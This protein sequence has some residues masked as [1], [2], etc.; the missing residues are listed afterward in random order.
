MESLERR[1]PAWRVT[2]EIGS[3]EGVTA[4][5]STSDLHWGEYERMDWG[6]I[7][8]GVKS[9][10]KHHVCHCGARFLATAL[11]ACISRLSMPGLSGLTAF[12][13]AVQHVSS[14]HA[15]GDQAASCYCMRKGLIRKA[16]LAHNMKKWAAKH[17]GMCENTHSP[18]L[19][20][21][22]P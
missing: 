3:E 5:A 8:E 7:H 10:A 18:I 16:H 22:S 4:A 1:Q 19:H 13:L 15:T 2:A 17:Q 20:C 9:V 14:W 21:S 11:Q 12:S 6:R